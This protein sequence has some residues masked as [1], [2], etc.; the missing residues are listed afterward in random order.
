[1]TGDHAAT[2]RA[3]AEEIEIVT[4]DDPPS[5]IMTAAQFNKLGDKEIDALPELPLVIAR[6]D[7]ETKV[8]MILAAGR[9]G[10]YTAMTGDGVNDAPSLKLAPVGIAMGMEGSDVAKDASELVLTGKCDCIVG[11]MNSPLIAPADDNFDSVRLAISEGRR[12]FDNIQRFILHLRKFS[13]RRIPLLG[14]TFE[15]VC[16][17]VGECILLVLGLAFLDSTDHSVFPLSP[18]SILWINMVTS[19]PPAFGLGMEPPA[20]RVMK[21]PP[22]NIKKGVFT[23]Q[24][25]ID[26]LYYGLVMGITV[27]IAFVVVVW[28]RYNGDLGTECNRADT[29]GDCVY[30]FRA[31]STVFAT[32]ILEI[33]LFAWELKAL[34][35]SMFNITPGRPFYEDLWANKI[36]F[37][38]VV[39]GCASIPLAIY[40]PVFNSRVFYQAPISA[41]CLSISS[42][43][44]STEV[45]V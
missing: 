38:T 10:K 28:G 26:I 44:Q 29:N 42:S 3:I 18:L 1:L 5:A 9:R 7:P 35:R 31:R 45:Y 40:I 33:L 4:P 14:L 24:I 11:S 37:W 17:N 30:V 15:I 12:I 6:C 21:R 16:V 32:L 20:A 8:R 22:H 25:I 41:Y 27:M 36:L 13:N 39:I 34:D 19:S 43:I 23:I 2:A